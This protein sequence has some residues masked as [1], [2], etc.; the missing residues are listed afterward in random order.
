MP[1]I[2]IDE[3]STEEL[4]ALESFWFDEIRGLVMALK[5]PDERKRKAMEEE[6]RHSRNRVSQ[7]EDA[8]ESARLDDADA[9]HDSAME[10]KEGD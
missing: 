6:L 4:E 5:T 9:I 7:I 10:L 2:T 8:L 3:L 1:K